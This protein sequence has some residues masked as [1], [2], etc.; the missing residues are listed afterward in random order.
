MTTVRIPTPLRPLV[1]GKDEVPV[2]GATVREVLRTLAAEHRGIGERICDDAGNVRRFVNVFVNS[3]D[4]RQLSGLDTPVG[5]KDTISLVPAIAGGNLIQDRLKSIRGRVREVGPRDVATRKPGTL[6]IDVREK[7]EYEQGYIPGA[8]HITRGFLE[9]EISEVAPDP[10][11]PI[12]CYCAGGTRSLFAA[13]DLLDLGYTNVK[14]LGGGFRKWK[15]EGQ[16]FDR[17]R[18]L[19]PEQ[20]KRYS[21]HLTIPEVGEEGQFKLLDAKVLCVGAGGLGSPAAYYLAA[22]GVGTLGIV[23]DDL[24][25]ESNLQRQILHSTKRVG[26]PKVESAT[27]TLSEFNPDIRI[28]GHKTRLTSENVEEICGGYDLI[29]DGSDNFPT[30]Y[31]VNDFCVK[32]RKPNVH[33][34]V[35]RFEGQATVF[36]PGKG[37]CYRCLFPEPPP[38]EF[39]PSCAEAGVLG[40]LPGI[41]GLLEAIETVKILIGK[42]DLL[43]GRLLCYDALR[44]RFTELR[45]DRD[46]TCAYCADG[47]AFPGY[48]DYAR[49]CAAAR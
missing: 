38:P 28:Q 3:Q 5:E 43:V 23:D 11:T 18:V 42:G 30:R 25:D 24:V 33:G 19:S 31:L 34:S 27:Q 14:S 16:P 7:D 9:L 17:P 46:P 35:F 10:E 8:V 40:V 44:A 29:L 6:V 4:I 20:Q 26:V 21:R 22:A 1:G 2:A 36:W 39:A 12:V 48:V 15:E 37:P 41:I 45:L 49:F 32:H 13:N 47:A